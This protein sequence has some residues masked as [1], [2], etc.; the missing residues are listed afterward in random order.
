MAIADVFIRLC[1][2]VYDFTGTCHIYDV[3]G[4]S[5]FILHESDITI[6]LCDV[7]LHVQ[8]L[9]FSCSVWNVFLHCTDNRL[10]F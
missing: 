5:L 7:S 3:D 1:G 8:K 2:Y 6:I 10:G 4:V 9:L